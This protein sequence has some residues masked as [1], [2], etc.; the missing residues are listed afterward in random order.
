[1]LPYCCLF[2]LTGFFFLFLSLPFSR[3]LIKTMSDRRPSAQ[4]SEVHTAS[5]SSRAEKLLRASPDEGVFF[6][7]FARFAGK[8]AFLRFGK[9]IRGA[10]RLFRI[11][12]ES[13]AN[14]LSHLRRAIYFYMSLM[15]L[16][17][18]N[19]KYIEKVRVMLN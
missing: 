2:F 3:S 15:F 9:L 8:C 17:I 4:T 18:E 7:F 6:L 16:I 11:T 5:P 12:I 10:K 14:K 19:G 13:L 1:M